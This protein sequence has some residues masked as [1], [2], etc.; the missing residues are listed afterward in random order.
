LTTF[1]AVFRFTF[2]DSEKRLF[3]LEGYCFRGSIDDWIYLVGPEELEN[4]AKEY[5]KHLGQE[6][7]YELY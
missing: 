2:Q 6:S 1:S 5:L 7:F 4:L 3:A